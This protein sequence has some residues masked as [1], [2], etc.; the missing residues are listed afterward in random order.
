MP[1]REAAL[2]RGVKE[3]D[4][5]PKRYETF[6]MD[7]DWVQH[8]RSSLLGLEDGATSSREDINTSERFMPRVAASEP[9]PPEVVVNHWLPILQEQGYLTECH[10]DKFTAVEDWVPLYTPEGLEKHLPAAL[11]AFASTEPPSL[12]AVVPLQ[13]HVGTDRKFLLMSFHRHEYLV[14]QSINIGGKHR[15]LAFCSYCGVINENSKT[16]LS[17]VRKH[18]DLLF[19]CGGCYAKSFPH[20][21]ALN[22]HMKT[23]CHATSAIREKARAPRK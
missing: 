10:P 21:Q 14:R 12:M 13:I 2:P 16:A 4:I 3:E 9:E 8:V 17:H 19:V 5:L 11:S 7:N 15:Q 6:S 1:Q 23:M 18:L 20:G 22:K